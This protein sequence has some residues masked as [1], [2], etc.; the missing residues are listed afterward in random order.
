MSFQLFGQLVCSLARYLVTVGQDQR[1]DRAELRTEK[2]NQGLE[3]VD[4]ILIRIAHLADEGD[5]I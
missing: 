2:I 1:R 4:V 3:R 5:D